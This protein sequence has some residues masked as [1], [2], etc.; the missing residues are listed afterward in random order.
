MAR[1]KPLLRE[2]IKV[3][4][5]AFGGKPILNITEVTKWLR[6]DRKTVVKKFTFKEGKISVVQLASEML[7]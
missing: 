5:D 2:Q 1:E 7:P 4:N 3:I 6:M